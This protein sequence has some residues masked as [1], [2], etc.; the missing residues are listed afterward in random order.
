MLDLMSGRYL[1]H[2]L[3]DIRWGKTYDDPP[4]YFHVDMSMNFKKCKFTA[5][6]IFFYYFISRSNYFC[7]HVQYDTE[8][9]SLYCKVWICSGKGYEYGNV[10]YSQSF[11]FWITSCLCTACFLDFNYDDGN[12]CCQIHQKKKNTVWLYSDLSSTIIMRKG[13]KGGSRIK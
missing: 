6:R 13:V 4:I 11:Y 10:R 5:D 9:Y 12:N 2:P 3:Q 1:Q 7:C 8:Q